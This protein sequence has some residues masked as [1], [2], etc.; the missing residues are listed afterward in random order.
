MVPGVISVE[1]RVG[2]SSLNVASSHSTL[3]I[4][5]STDAGGYLVQGRRL[6]L[7]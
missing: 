1:N 6:H 2:H 7:I 5:D 3:L 4:S